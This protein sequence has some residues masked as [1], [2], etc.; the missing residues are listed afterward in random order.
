MRSTLFLLLSAIGY[1][2]YIY[3]CH[4]KI[5]TIAATP[6]KYETIGGFERYKKSI[7]Y[8]RK[9]TLHGIHYYASLILC[10]PLHFLLLLLYGGLGVLLQTYLLIPVGAYRLSSEG[11]MI[12]ALGGLFFSIALI[13]WILFSVNRPIFVAARLYGAKDPDNYPLSLQ[14]V[15]RWLLVCGIL[16]LPIMVLGLNAYSY[17]D[18]SGIVTHNLICPMERSI[19]FT[20]MVSGETSYSPGEGNTAFHLYYD[21]TLEDGTVFSLSDFEPEQILYIHTLLEDNSIP[22]AY[23][24]ISTSDYEALKPKLDEEDLLLATTLLRQEP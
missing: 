23:G 11:L 1:I 13:E 19:P 14:S 24:T 15:Y 18:P 12:G 16:C 3:L 22:V 8:Q 9:V 4:R 21:I 5:K 2:F 7:W 17:V 10:I 20:S 6:W